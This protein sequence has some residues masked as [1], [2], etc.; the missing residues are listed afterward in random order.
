MVALP[1][2]TPKIFR[3]TDLDQYRTAVRNLK[4]EFTP[5]ARKIS[6]EQVILNLPGCDINFAKSFPRIADGELAE[7]CTAIGFSMDDGFPI[8]FNGVERDRA[9]FVM[10]SGG[11]AYSTV[12]RAERKFTSII[13][14]QKME[15]RGWPRAGPNWKMFETSIVAQHRLRELVR[16]VLSASPTFTA[17]E[18]ADASVAIRES[19]LAGVDAAFAEVVDARWAARG[20]SIKQFKV[21]RNIQAVLS[22]NIGR[23]IYSEELARELGISVRAMHD[24]VQRYQGMSLHRYLRLKR[25]WLVRQK[26]LAGGDSVKACALAFGFWHLG[27]FARSY[28]LH[29]GETPSDTLA[30]SRQR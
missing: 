10:G 24:A 3:F 6:A 14:T 13:F 8:R 1:G 29:F 26:L 15:N 21:L 30:K 27:D 16:L 28:R 11:A 25:L 22:G 17:C 5:L 19:L 7:N 12:E 20:N 4:V 9:A 2:L 18:V 23:P